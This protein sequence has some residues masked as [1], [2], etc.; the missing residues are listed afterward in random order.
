MVIP[1]VGL[2]ALPV[3]FARFDA[4]RRLVAWNAGFAAI[5]GYPRRLLKAGTP[6]ERFVRFEVE[7]GDYGEGKVDALLRKRLAA[8]SKAASREVTLARGRVVCIVSR[9]L[10]AKTLLITCE[11]VTPTRRV[12]ARLREAEE[13][14]ELSMRSLNE[15]TY[16]W[17]I[18]NNRIFYSDRVQLALGLS[19]GEITTPGDWRDR[20]HP[21]DLPRFDAAIVAH[22]KGQSERFE[23]DYRFRG[24][25]GSWRWARQHGIAIRDAS[26]RAVRMVGS[27]GDITELKHTEAALKQSEERY[28][29]ATR[30]AAEGIYEWDVEANSLFLTDRALEFFAMPSSEWLTPADWNA[31]IHPDDFDEYRAALRDYFKGLGDQLQHEYRVADADGGYRWILDRGIAVRNS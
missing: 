13:R 27:N 3:G 19:P 1:N 26:G 7:R 8:L 22:L 29:L 18:A 28:A 12:E 15:G 24:K 4:Q 25:D 11:D 5:G 31:R 21:E 14:H 17:N 30:A 20:I 16:D 23:C 10:A 2:D 9:P 6:L